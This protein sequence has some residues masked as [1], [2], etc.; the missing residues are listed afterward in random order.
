MRPPFKANHRGRE[1][2]SYL[3]GKHPAKRPPG[4]SPARA[5]P[6]PPQNGRSNGRR[7]RPRAF[8]CTS[9]SSDTEV[10]ILC[11]SGAN[12]HITLRKQDLNN[13]RTV[14]RSCTFG[15]KGQLQALAMGVSRFAC[16]CKE[17]K[18]PRFGAPQWSRARAQESS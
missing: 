11:D 6:P 3:N 4:M 10:S 13:T 17:A 2:R 14:N 8:K 9:T 15:N 18:A 1:C 16:E 5:F 12:I 7:D